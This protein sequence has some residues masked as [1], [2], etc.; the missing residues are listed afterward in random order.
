MGVVYTSK[1]SRSNGVMDDITSTNLCLY[2]N[3]YGKGKLAVFLILN[4][5]Q[6]ISFYKTVFFNAYFRLVMWS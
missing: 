2:K 6:P 1:I 4:L 3:I 5:G